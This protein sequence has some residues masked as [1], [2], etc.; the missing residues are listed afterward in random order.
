MKS[1][2]RDY[3]R[4]ARAIHFLDRHAGEEPKPS[5][6]DVARSVGLSPFHF[7]RLFT[8]WAGVSPKR[9]QQFQQ[10]ASARNVLR[11]APNVLHASFGAG[12]S[13]PGRLHDLFVRVEAVTP[14][15]YR[16]GGAGITLA[17]GIHESP[18]GRYLLALTGRGIAGL[19]FLDERGERGGADDLVE[20]W[21]NASIL[22]RPR[23]TA[24]VAAR[25]F[26][27]TYPEQ[28]LHL[29]LKGTNF[30]LK[31]WE[32]LLRIPEGTVLTYEDI[33][34]RIGTVRATRAVGGAIAANPI[35]WLI[36]CHRVIRKTGAF[37]GY[38]WGVDRKRAL[39]AWEAVT[40]NRVLTPFHV[41]R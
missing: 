6:E 10:V 30:Q 36:P 28:P 32:A 26:T 20:R 38:R 11:S 40:V 24:E 34:G 5:L 1:T 18:F 33:A 35:A 8:R 16:S 17:W 22:H 2:T 12:L 4:I 19:A 41:H 15:E 25:L 29:L 21:P 37:G 3:D 23:E 14:G 27:R 31:V 39:L 13:G 7:Q 9:F